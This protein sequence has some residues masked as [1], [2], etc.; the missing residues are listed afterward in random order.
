VHQQS[1][2]LRFVAEEDQYYGRRPM[3]AGGRFSRATGYKT[4]LMASGTLS[5]RLGLIG[6]HQK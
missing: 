5:T 3:V 4:K 2:Y 6:V 1:R